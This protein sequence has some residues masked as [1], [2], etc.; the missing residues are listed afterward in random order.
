MSNNNNPFANLQPS[1]NQS[2]GFF[3]EY[4]TTR[5]QVVVDH[6][7]DGKEIGWT[8]IPQPPPGPGW[9]IAPSRNDGHKTLWRRFVPAKDSGRGA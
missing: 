4:M 3:I 5:D 2:I 8:C 7:R 9:Q 1:I 6:D